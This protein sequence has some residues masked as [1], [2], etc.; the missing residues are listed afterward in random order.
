[1]KSLGCL[2]FILLLFLSPVLA[3]D[4][5]PPNPEKYIEDPFVRQ[6]FEKMDGEKKAH[7][8]GQAEAARKQ[9]EAAE[10]A[11]K[12]KRTAE[13]YRESRNARIKKVQR[14]RGQKTKSWQVLN[15]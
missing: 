15:R 4:Y 13:A 2:A 10:E 7:Q 1:M 8:E 6:K 5:H 14:T 3:G 11:A 12:A 9:Q